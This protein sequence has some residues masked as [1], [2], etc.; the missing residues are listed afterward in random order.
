MYNTIIYGNEGFGHEVYIWDVRSAPSFLYSD[1]EGDTTDF[2]GSGA[3]G[4]YH[5]TYDHNIDTDPLFRNTGDF[6]NALLTGSPCIDAG[7]PDTAGLQIPSTDLEGLSR[8]YNGT[9]DIGAFEWNPGQSSFQWPAESQGL[10]ATPNPATDQ[11]TFQYTSGPGSA[12]NLK[13]LS[14]TGTA[15]YESPDIPIHPGRNDI[16]W[17]LRNNAGN[18]VIAGIYIC[19]FK[20]SSCILVVQ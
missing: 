13:V 9:I 18:R 10:F 1:V 6:P 19:C 17:D 20:G 15:L 16:A 8:I 5:G 12:G 14:M 11:T 2:E 4:G 7:T 3:H